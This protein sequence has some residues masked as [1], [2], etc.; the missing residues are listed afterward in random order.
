MALM[1][2]LLILG[3]VPCECDPEI[4]LYVGC[5]SQ[6]ASL[7]NLLIF[8]FIHADASIYSL[9]ILIKITKQSK[10][11]HLPIWD[12]DRLMHHL[13]FVHQQKPL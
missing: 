7:A 9:W 6:I 13:S 5:D 10:S 8:L 4:Q 1:V 11:K 3:L 2:K 12:W